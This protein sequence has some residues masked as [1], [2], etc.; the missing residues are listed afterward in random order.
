MK[1]QHH[2][3]NDEISKLQK[4]L[5]NQNKKTDQTEEKNPIDRQKRET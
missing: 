4:L 5:G 3:G 2:V 1:P